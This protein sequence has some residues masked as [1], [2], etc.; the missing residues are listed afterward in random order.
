MVGTQRQHTGTAGRIE[1]S[2]VAVYLV[3]AGPQGHAFLDRQLYLPSSWT[4]DP[5]R[6]A[7]AG[8]PDQVAFATKPA[9]ARV[10]VTRAL[11]ADAGA[12]VRRRRGRRQRSA[13]AS[14]PA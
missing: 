3:D 7:A 13:A 11:A 12:V 4:D 6:C 2:Q 5:H 10:M 9:L 1:N 14:R 8:I